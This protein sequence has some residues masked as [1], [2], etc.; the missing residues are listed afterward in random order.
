MPSAS[1]VLV[2]VDVL[3]TFTTGSDQGKF[4]LI[5]PKQKTKN[6]KKQTKKQTNKQTNKQNKT[7][8]KHLTDTKYIHQL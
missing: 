7:K 8:T 6:K 5:R 4:S 1:P 2:I 3:R